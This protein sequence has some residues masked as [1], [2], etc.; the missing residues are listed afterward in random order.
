MRRRAL[1][2]V[3]AATVGLVLAVSAGAITFGAND[4]GRHPMV[5]AL[6]ADL[7]DIGNVQWCSGTLIASNVF[8]TASHCLVGFENIT[9]RV[10]FDEVLDADADGIVDPGVHLIDGTRHANPAY[11]SGGANDTF[12]VAV[13][14][15]DENPCLTRAS[16]P[17]AGLLDRRDVRSAR[18]TAVGYGTVRDDKR[19][20]PQTFQL[21]TRRKYVTQSVN[22][23]T[24]AWATFSM[25]PSTGNGGTCYGDSGGPH[26]LGA[27]SSETTTVVSLTVTGDATCRA[28]DKTYRLDTPSARA[29]LGDFVALP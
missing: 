24:K 25:N 16:L 5:G 20:G 22:S 10:T 17:Q 29:F 3:A 18:F 2:A 9:F 4:N 14:V 13:I 6:V 15:L 12:D 11:A 26:F 19:K 27:G 1:I 28:T 23:V 7:P 8:L 21:G